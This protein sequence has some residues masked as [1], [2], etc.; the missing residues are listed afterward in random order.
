MKLFSRRTVVFIVLI[1]FVLKIVIKS[2][3]FIFINL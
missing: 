3:V 2:N 1:V